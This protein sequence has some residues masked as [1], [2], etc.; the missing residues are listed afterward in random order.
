M[1]V[2]RPALA[3]AGPRPLR[4]RAQAAP[5]PRRSTTD[6]AAAV[7]RASRCGSCGR[8]GRCAASGTRCRS[9]PRRSIGLV[10]LT[11]LYYEEVFDLRSATRLRRRRRRA[12]AGR[13]HPARDP[14]AS[15]MMLQDPAHRP[16][17]AR[18]SSAVDHR[19]RLGRFT[20]RADLGVAMIAMNIAIS[21]SRVARPGHLRDAVAHDPAQGPIAR[22]RDG[23]AVHPA[24]PDRAVH[25]R[26]ASPTAT[27]MR[28]GLL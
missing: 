4:A 1:V 16:A 27:A 8:S 9:S 15:R 28:G 6:E 11:S 12:R 25:R 26:A 10:A 7:V 17:P 21:G 2:A 22:I 23:V 3:G 13:R 20:P 5:T 24:R 14:L 18:R 19:G